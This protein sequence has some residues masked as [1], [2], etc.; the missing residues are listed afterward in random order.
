MRVNSRVYDEKQ[1][2]FQNIRVPNCPSE[3]RAVAE[4]I[5]AM[6]TKPGYALSDYNTMTELDK[7]LMWDYW[8]EYDGFIHTAAE[9]I[10][11]KNSPD[12]VT[13]GGLRKW[14]IKKATPPE[15][16]RRARQWLTEHRY[17]IVKE[18]VAQNAQKAGQKFRQSVRGG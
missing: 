2:I 5:L 1:D 4:N 17:L 8:V 12:K 10:L 15:L 11:D 16:I 3:F 9:I 18:T 14:F 13:S 7:T 6:A